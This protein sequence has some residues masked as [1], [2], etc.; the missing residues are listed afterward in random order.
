MTGGLCPS[1]TGIMVRLMYIGLMYP[2]VLEGGSSKLMLVFGGPCSAHLASN[3]YLT[4]LSKIYVSL[5][6]GV[7]GLSM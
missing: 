4:D 2:S 7:Q 5:T 3:T 1:H 6:I